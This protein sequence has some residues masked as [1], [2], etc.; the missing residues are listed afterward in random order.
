MISELIGI[1]HMSRSL[2]RRFGEAVVAASLI[3]GTPAAA[4]E[5]FPTKQERIVSTGEEAR[6][7]LFHVGKK[8][9]V[10]IIP[11]QGAEVLKQFEQAAAALP[12]KTQEAILAAAVAD[13]FDEGTPEN[14][15]FSLELLRRHQYPD[16]EKWEKKAWALFLKRPADVIAYLPMYAERPDASTKFDEALR[17]LVYKPPNEQEARK[18]SRAMVAHERERRIERGDEYRIDF[19]AL[20]KKLKGNRDFPSLLASLPAGMRWNDRPGDV[21]SNAHQYGYLWDAIYDALQQGAIGKEDI[22]ELAVNTLKTDPEL[23]ISF[24]ERYVGA[25]SPPPAFLFHAADRLLA[26]VEQER[27]TKKAK[28]VAESILDRTNLFAT[29]LS[30]KESWNILARAKRIILPPIGAVASR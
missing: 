21:Q 14:I 26:G 2:G 16:L 17:A 29:F 12:A 15:I 11:H 25:Y 20:L 9:D 5:K 28:Q 4:Q 1:S 10:V 8:G 19:R 13:I 7:E 6:L 27:E 22:I 23:G 3:A 24:F 30:A 18:T